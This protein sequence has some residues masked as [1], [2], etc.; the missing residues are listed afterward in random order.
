MGYRLCDGFF[1]CD[2]FGEDGAFPTVA[3]LGGRGRQTN[4][5]SHFE[6][7]LVGTQT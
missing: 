2:I 5:R 6:K 1:K 4:G 3:L 7:G